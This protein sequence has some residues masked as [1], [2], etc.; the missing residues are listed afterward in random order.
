[1]KNRVVLRVARFYED[2]QPLPMLEEVGLTRLKTNIAFSTGHDLGSTGRYIYKEISSD[3]EKLSEVLNAELSNNLIV[4]SGR[5]PTSKDLRVVVSRDALSIDKK[6][7]LE[8]DNLILL[9]FGGSETGWDMDHSGCCPVRLRLSTQ[10]STILKNVIVD[11]MLDIYLA[12]SLPIWP[13]IRNTLTVKGRDWLYKEKVQ[14]AKERCNGD[15][16]YGKISDRCGYV[17]FA[18]IARMDSTLVFD[19]AVSMWDKFILEKLQ[20]YIPEP[21]LIAK[22]LKKRP[23]IGGQLKKEEKLA[24][25]IA[26]LSGGA[27]LLLF[28]NKYKGLE[29]ILRSNPSLPASRHGKVAF[30]KADQI[31]KGL[32]DMLR[33]RKLL[34]L[35]FYKL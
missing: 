3:A 4:R 14:F 18:S 8:Q 22:D 1:M 21:E 16:A 35:K 19:K 26:Q 32:R 13:I 9:S 6:E 5:R 33:E 2:E 29:P 34:A 7:N 11:I 28:T 15:T 31:D 30:I 20:A 25:M 17:P 12:N 27:W 23:A 10:T 24:S